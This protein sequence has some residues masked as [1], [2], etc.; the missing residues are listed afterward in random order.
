[1]D[2]RWAL[3][4]ARNW[5]IAHCCHPGSCPA[6]LSN[7]SAGARGPCSCVRAKP[8]WRS[9]K[10]FAELPFKTPHVVR[11]A[12]L[13]SLHENPFDRLLLALAVEEALTL[14]TADTMIARYVSFIWVV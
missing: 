8:H 13:P 2:W 14:R 6:S 1:M 3:T 12:S 11:M 10:R 7:P 9:A 5:W 4:L